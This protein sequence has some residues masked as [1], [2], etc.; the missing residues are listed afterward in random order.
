[1][2]DWPSA[3]VWT[4][5]TKS[6]ATGQA[7]VSLKQGHADFAQGG[8][9]IGIAERA[10]FGEAVKD[11]REAFGQIFKHTFGPFACCFTSRI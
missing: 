2:T 11:A 3:L 8:G 9:D 5:L 4:A 7:D 10:L 1:M 6:R